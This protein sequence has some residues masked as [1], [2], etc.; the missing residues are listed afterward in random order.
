M[1]KQL[2]LLISIIAVF[3]ILLTNCDDKDEKN[4]ECAKTVV[5][6]IS[7][8]FSIDIIVKTK[9]SVPWSGPVTMMF[10]KEYCNLETSGEYTFTGVCDN[11]GYFYPNAIPTY[12]YGNSEDCV[13]I[14]VRLQESNTTQFI[15]A[16]L[17]E[18]Y[19]EDVY[20]LITGV[21]ETYEIYLSWYSAAK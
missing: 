5:P 21:E 11:D 4:E 7:R 15:N 1:K 13:L 9:D 2:F 18:Y 17:Y 20:P 6:E 19:Y 12:T 10:W 16:R 3:S 8:G 14:K